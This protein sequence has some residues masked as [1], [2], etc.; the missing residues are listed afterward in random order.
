[1][2]WQRA[3]VC[4][5][6]GARGA[7]PAGRQEGPKCATPRPL[8]RQVVAPGAVAV[9]FWAFGV[10]AP[11]DTPPP[12][13]I[14]GFVAIG[15][16]SCCC[17]ESRCRSSD[18][19]DTDPKRTASARGATTCINIVRTPA[20]RLATTTAGRPNSD[21]TK[22]SGGGVS[23]GA[24]TQNALKRTASARGATTCINIVRTPATRLA[25]TTAGKPDS[26]KTKDSGG[27]GGYPGEH[28]P[29]TH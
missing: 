24:R 22:D 20:T 18:D 3:V 23:W 4:R 8:G 19:I 7:K 14:L 6:R 25:T 1:M 17:C 13:G 9:G 12:P 28:G 5:G 10:R 11:P 15:L 26:D 16:A 29:K 2:V 27:G 21:K